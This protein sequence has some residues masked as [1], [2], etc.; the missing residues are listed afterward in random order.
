MLATS[1]RLHDIEDAEG[2]VAATVQR[3]GLELGAAEHE[4]LIAEG[5]CILYE[6]ADRYEP[7][8]DGYAHAGTFSGF[9][10]QFLPRRLGDAWHR[11]NPH[12]HRIAGEDGKRRWHYEDPPLSLD[13]LR[14]S[15]PIRGGGGGRQAIE[16]HV[17]PASHWAQASA[18][19][20]GDRARAVG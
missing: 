15:T 2:F 13:H 1:V 8:R 11:N 7:H 19:P 3:A 17:R 12:H 4:E 18:R 10:A 16:I 5:I 20:A 6:L 9:A 14:S